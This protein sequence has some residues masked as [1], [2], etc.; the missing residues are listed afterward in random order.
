VKT[1]KIGSLLV[2]YD[3]SAVLWIRLTT[4]LGQWIPG[5]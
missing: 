2:S 4:S 5:G 1:G 3:A